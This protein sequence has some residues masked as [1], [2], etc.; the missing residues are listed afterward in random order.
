MTYQAR[1][2][3]DSQRRLAAA[4]SARREHVSTVRGSN[5]LIYHSV[6]QSGGR[7]AV[8]ILT[9]EQALAA[10]ASIQQCMTQK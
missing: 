3:S 5:G 6:T 10:I 7:C 9:E 8:A 4:Q 2:E 1:L